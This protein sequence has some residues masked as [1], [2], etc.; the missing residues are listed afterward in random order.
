[1]TLRFQ[2][3]PIYNELRQNIAILDICID[4]KYISSS[5]HKDYV[6]KLEVLIKK[7]YAFRRRILQKS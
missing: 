1:M 6:L 4:Q 7:L 5:T 2:N 3:F